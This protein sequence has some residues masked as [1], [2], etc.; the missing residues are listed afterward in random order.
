MNL[1]DVQNGY[2]YAI[3]TKPFWMEP[4]VAIDATKGLRFLL[5]SEANIEISSNGPFEISDELIAAANSKGLEFSEDQ[6]CSLWSERFSSEILDQLFSNDSDK[7]RLIPD[8]LLDWTTMI[9]KPSEELSTWLRSSKDW[10]GSSSSVFYDTD[11]KFSGSFVTLFTGNPYQLAVLLTW[12]GVPIEIIKG[13][14]GIDS[15]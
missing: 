7:D 9:P 4:F 12:L 2:L 11:G 6:I 10:P 15:V 3:K 13:V 14:T 8:G 5:A 1:H